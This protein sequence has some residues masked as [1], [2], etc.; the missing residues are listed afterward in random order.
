MRARCDD[1]RVRSLIPTS[2]PSIVSEVGD[3]IDIHAHYATEWLDQGGVRANFI[4]SA[5]GAISANGVSRGLQTAGDNRVFAALRD[6]ADVVLVGS[7]TAVAEGYQPVVLAESR[8]S[9]RAEHGLGDTLPVAVISGSLH[10]DPSARLFGDAS[11][12]VFTTAGGD[13][14]VRQALTAEVIECGDDQLDIAQIIGALRARGLR[15]VLCEGGPTLL[16]TIA[17]AGVM[18]E[19]CLTVSP[20]LVGP[21]PG[22]LTAGAGWSGPRGTSLIGLLEEDGALFCRYRFQ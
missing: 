4:A 2:G 10:F 6:L 1:G 21:G 12:M 9:R 7:G 3:D 14:D 13:Q 20:V 16:A 8:V 18:D 19:L 17:E 15:R 22:R 11:T 5:D